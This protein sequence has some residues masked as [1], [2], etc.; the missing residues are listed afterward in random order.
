MRLNASMNIY[1]ESL[2]YN[3]GSYYDST[4]LGFLVDGVNVGTAV[5]GVKYVN[6]IWSLTPG[7]EFVYRRPSIDFFAGAYYNYVF[8]YHEKI[9]FNVHSIPVS[10]A[11]YY[12]N[13]TP[14]SR[15]VVNLGKYTI[16]VGIIREFGL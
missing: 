8:S 1:F 13:E 2:T 7:L 10:D 9:N 3:F 15:S 4:Q 6:D 14:V 11:I 12:Q 16:Q 5:K